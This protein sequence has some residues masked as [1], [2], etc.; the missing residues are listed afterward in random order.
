MLEKLYS[1]PVLLNEVS[2]WTIKYP[3]DTAPCVQLCQRRC[4]APC[5]H[6]KPVSDPARARS[7]SPVSYLCLPVSPSTLSPLTQCHFL[8]CARKHTIK[9]HTCR[10]MIHNIVTLTPLISRA[11]KSQQMHTHTHTHGEIMAVILVQHIIQTCLME[12][13]IVYS[14]WQKFWWST[15]PIFTLVL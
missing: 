5:W 10:V 6:D 12:S 1:Y 7:L 9:G 2:I 8:I 4:R 14:V 11:N 15:C 13:G 3:V